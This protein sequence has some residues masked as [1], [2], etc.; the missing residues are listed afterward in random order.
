LNLSIDDLQKV[1][2]YFVLELEVALKVHFVEHPH[3]MLAANFD[4]CAWVRLSS[5]G[6]VSREEQLAKVLHLISVALVMQTLHDKPRVSKQDTQRV[7]NINQHAFHLAHRQ[8]H[9]VQLMNF[10]EA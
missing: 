9:L 3:Y 10:Y 1:S 6:L 7:V 2:Q 4:C 5:F 8:F